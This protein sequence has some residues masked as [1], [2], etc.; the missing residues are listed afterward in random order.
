M[1]AEAGKG[2]STVDKLRFAVGVAPAA[3]SLAAT[4]LDYTRQKQYDDPHLAC[5]HET[6]SSSRHTTI[7]PK[8]T[9]PTN[10]ASGGDELSKAQRESRKRYEKVSPAG[11]QTYQQVSASGLVVSGALGDAKQIS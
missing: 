5:S 8:E 11:A 7:A 4:I 9:I 3:I 2:S 1:L 10:R 6:A